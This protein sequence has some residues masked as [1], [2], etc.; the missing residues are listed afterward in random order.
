MK[1]D[2]LLVETQRL[3]SDRQGLSEEAFWTKIKNKE[4]WRDGWEGFY[5]LDTINHKDFYWESAGPD[6]IFGTKDDIREPAWPIESSPSPWGIA[7][8][9]VNKE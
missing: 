1:L 3:F 2:R 6:G 8:P 4:A 5:R 7:D 9:I